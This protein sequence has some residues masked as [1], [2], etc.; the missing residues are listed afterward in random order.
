MKKLI[1]ALWLVGSFFVSYAQKEPL[2]T[3]Y[4]VPIDTITKLITY[5]GV[6]EVK[7]TPAAALYKRIIDWFNT[8]YK[9]PTEVIRENDSVGNMVM[10]KPRFRITNLP[11]NDLEKTA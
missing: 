1:L 2:V 10:G 3:P 8:Y 4:A 11:A 5:Q 6:V 9:N 7:N